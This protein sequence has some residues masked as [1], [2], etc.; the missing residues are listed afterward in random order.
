MNIDMGPKGALGLEVKIRGTVAFVGGTN[1][2][3]EWAHHFIPLAGWREIRWAR[4]LLR[5]LEGFPI[6]T[7]AGHS[8]GGT[9]ATAATRIR[10]DRGQQTSLY[11]YGAKRPPRGYMANGNHYVA[12]GDRVPYMNK[13]RPSLP[14]IVMDY[15]ELT[16]VEAHGPS[17]YYEQMER[18]G[19]R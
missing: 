19:V 8:V 12:K 16:Q 13:F 9:V 5:E 7:L 15:G 11:T 10:R 14:L 3:L 1:H 2:W 17:I 6:S 4:R 18:D